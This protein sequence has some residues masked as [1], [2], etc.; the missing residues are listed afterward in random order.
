M[1]I[2]DYLIGKNAG[3]GGGSA[4]L[5]NKEVTITENGT[6]EV[7]PDSGYDGLKKVEITTNVSGKGKVKFLNYYRYGSSSSAG[8][9]SAED[10][11]KVLDDLTNNI[12]TSL[13]TDFNTCFCYFNRNDN[14]EIKKFPKLDYSSAEDVIGMFSNAHFDEIDLS[15]EL[16]PGIIDITGMFYNCSAKKINLKDYVGDDLE[17]IS[18]T[19]KSA[20]RN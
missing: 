6:S 8:I 2:V 4:K 17:Y 18:G 16:F 12:D 19:N 14:V 15:G 1:E 9:T 20:I 7:K 5:Q 13:V 11:N 3:G 10:V